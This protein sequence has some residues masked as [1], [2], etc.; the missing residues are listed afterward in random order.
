MCLRC[1][2]THTHTV[3]PP[4]SGLNKQSVEGQAFGR[5]L[6]ECQRVKQQIEQQ[7]Q[8]DAALS[9]TADETPTAA[10][11]QGSTDL[12]SGAKTM[13]Q[14]DCSRKV[15]GFTGSARFLV[16]LLTRL[17]GLRPGRVHS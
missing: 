14:L 12:G 16:R 1:S 2:N 10:E 9:C 17:L 6:Q 8:Q 11:K 5:W 7:Q 13:K 3:T 15:F 4:P